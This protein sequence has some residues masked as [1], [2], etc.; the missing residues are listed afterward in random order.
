MASACR[1]RRV[2]CVTMSLVLCTEAVAALSHAPPPRSAHP[3]RH[4]TWVLSLRQSRS[5]QPGIEA[6]RLSSPS[7]R[8]EAPSVIRSLRQTLE[9]SSLGDPF[10]QLYSETHRFC[11]LRSVLGKPGP[12]RSPPEGSGATS[13]HRSRRNNTPGFPLLDGEGRSDDALASPVG[14]PGAGPS[15]RPP[16]RR[17]LTQ[18]RGQDLPGGVPGRQG[19]VVGR[20]GRATVVGRA[21]QELDQ[22]VWDEI[23]ALRWW[24]RGVATVRRAPTAPKRQSVG[25]QRLPKRQ[26][27]GLQRLPKPEALALRG[28]APAADYREDPKDR[29]APQEQHS[30]RHNDSHQ[31]GRT[32]RLAGRLRNAQAHAY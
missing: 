28:A 10:E 29:D 5:Y 8:T 31:R 17:R 2:R 7:A 26:S 25:L 21:R 23:S 14:R 11:D 12:S 6:R 27:V 4:P 19:W 1:V 18:R 32:A 15:G 22:L 13:G 3:H 24:G 16:T 9:L 30:E 20:R